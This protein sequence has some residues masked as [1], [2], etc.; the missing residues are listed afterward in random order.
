MFEAPTRLPDGTLSIPKLISKEPPQVTAVDSTTMRRRIKERIL[1]PGLLVMLVGLM[2]MIVNGAVCVTAIFSP[3]EFVRQTKQE[4][5]DI[6]NFMNVE[7]PKVKPAENKDAVPNPAVPAKAPDPEIPAVAVDQDKPAE[8]PFVIADADLQI[9]VKTRRWA[10]F[11]F[12][13]T[14]LTTVIGAVCAITMKSHR[15]AVV[16][17]ITAMLNISNCCCV[18]GFPLGVWLLMVLLDAEVQMVF[19]LPTRQPITDEL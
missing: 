12:F 8:A 4:M 17:S 14:S 13:G 6:Q 7:P 10:T 11:F 1:F 16:G 3:D 19:S 5:Q 9:G 2:G 15:L 18:P